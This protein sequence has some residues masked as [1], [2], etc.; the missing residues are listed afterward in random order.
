[1][2]HSSC[3]SISVT[4]PLNRG[5][6]FAAHTL[7]VCLRPS[8]RMGA[9][10][11]NGRRSERRGFLLALHL[12]SGPAVEYVRPLFVRRGWISHAIILLAS[13]DDCSCHPSSPGQAR[14]S[15]VP[16]AVLRCQRKTGNPRTINPKP[17][18]DSP[19][20]V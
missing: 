3:E 13:N 20:L 10:A 11:S 6:R 2:A 18:A 4:A 12:A 1:M 17:A 7:Q 8:T 5:N 9:G 19:G 14:S 15:Y 16:V